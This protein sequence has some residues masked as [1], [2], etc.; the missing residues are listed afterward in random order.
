MSDCEEPTERQIDFATTIAET[1][2][3]DLPEHFDKYSY[4]EFIGEN[5][6]EFYKIQREIRYADGSVFHLQHS[7]SLGEGFCG[8]TELNVNPMTV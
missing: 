6:E 3:C 5:I 2:G 7:Y 1:V 4:S 8:D